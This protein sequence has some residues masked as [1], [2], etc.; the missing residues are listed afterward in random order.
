MIGVMAL[1]LRKGFPDVFSGG[2]C[3]GQQN[4]LHCPREIKKR[5]GGGNREEKKVRN[6]SELASDGVC[7]QGAF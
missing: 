6:I 1:P 4:G 7:S 3:G 5:G 2:I